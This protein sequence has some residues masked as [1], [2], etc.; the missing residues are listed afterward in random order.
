[1]QKYPTI[2]FSTS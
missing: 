2:F 1:M